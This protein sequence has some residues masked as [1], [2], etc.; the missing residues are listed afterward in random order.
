MQEANSTTVW[1]AL[2][3][4]VNTFTS[5]QIKVDC[6]LCSPSSTARLFLILNKELNKDRISRI[7]LTVQYNEML[8]S[9]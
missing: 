2:L 8:R 9:V 4:L 7:A 1:S 3:L 6:P 5:H